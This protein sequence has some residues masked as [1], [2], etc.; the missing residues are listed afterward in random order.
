[1]ERTTPYTPNIVG[2]CNY[3]TPQ[4]YW[5]SH[6]YCGKSHPNGGQI[7]PNGWNIIQLNEELDE[8]TY[9]NLEPIVFGVLGIVVSIKW[10]PN[11]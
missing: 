10:T 9:Y 5:I 4:Q 11:E 6:K 3:E 1:M 8:Y 2:H 7:V